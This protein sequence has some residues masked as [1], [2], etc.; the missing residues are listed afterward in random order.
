M[1]VCDDC[2][3]IFG[4]FHSLQNH[5][6]RWCNKCS[7]TE[8]HAETPPLKRWKS[9]DQTEEDVEDKDSEEYKVFGVVR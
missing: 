6:K 4:D 7:A 1:P 3:I 9:Y 8:D 2:G 5:V